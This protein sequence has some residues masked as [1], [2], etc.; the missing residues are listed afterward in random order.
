MLPAKWSDYLGSRKWENAALKLS[1]RHSQADASIP[2]V[3][4][5]EPKPNEDRLSK[6]RFSI[7]NWAGVIPRK[8]LLRNDPRRVR[9]L[10]GLSDSRDGDQRPALGSLPEARAAE[11]GL[12]HYGRGPRR[13]TGR[14]SSHRS[15]LSGLSSSR[16]ISSM[17]CCHESIVLVALASSSKAIFSTSI[18]P[19]SRSQ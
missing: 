5:D 12:E 14:S 7:F 11:D 4:G 8:L 17:P 13:G 19:N 16:C 1:G 18:G 15:R 3:N 10:L 6:R 9:R 2:S